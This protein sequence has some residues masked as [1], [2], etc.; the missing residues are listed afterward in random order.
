MMA[1]LHFMIDAVLGLISMSVVVHGLLGLLAS[2]EV[3]NRNNAFLNDLRRLLEA[4][5]APF[6]RPI[7]RVVPPLGGYDVSPILLV[8]TIAGVRMYL[9]PAIFH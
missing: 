7:Q 6:L 4:V 9:L 3:I 8:L 1:F 5:T 2:L